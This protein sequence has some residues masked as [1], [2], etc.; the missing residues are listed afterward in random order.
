MNAPYLSDFGG[1]IRHKEFHLKKVV[2]SCDFFGLL[3]EINHG[4]WSKIWKAMFH[5][6]VF[7]LCVNGQQG[8]SHDIRDKQNNKM[9]YVELREWK[10]TIWN[11]SKEYIHLINLFAGVS[12]NTKDVREHCVLSLSFYLPLLI[13]VVGHFYDFLLYNSLSPTPQHTECWCAVAAAL[14][15]DYSIH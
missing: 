9:A 6:F 7:F 13:L 12:F 11:L 4:T 14:Y 5:F 15:T 3:T 10:R 8:I 1:I 2:F